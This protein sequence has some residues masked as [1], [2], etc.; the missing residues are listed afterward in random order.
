MGTRS[1]TFIVDKSWDKDNEKPL[2]AIYKH[3][4][5][6]PTG[7]GVELAEWLSTRKVIN[8]IGM[9]QTA[10][11]GH[12]NGAGCLA[13]QLIAHFKAECGIGDISISHP[14]EVPGL[15]HDSW[16]EFYYTIYVDAENDFGEQ[17]LIQC[18][19][20]SNHLMYEGTPEK[21][22]EVIASTEEANG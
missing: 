15:E 9:N 21:F 8:G 19:D 14:R 20:H 7:W 1:L 5:G 17:F 6:Y 11:N 4:D 2:I 3:W 18:H 22:M 10:E 12:A 13:A 16:E